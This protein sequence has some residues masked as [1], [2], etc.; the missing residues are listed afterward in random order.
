MIVQGPV[1]LWSPGFGGITITSH[2]S[3]ADAMKGVFEIQLHPQW[4]W[5]H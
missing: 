3:V 5:S 2:G 1:P 4:R